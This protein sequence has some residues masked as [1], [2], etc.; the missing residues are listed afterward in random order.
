MARSRSPGGGGGGGG[1][2][3]YGDGLNGDG[4]S[5]KRFLKALSI[6]DK[7][8]PIGFYLKIRPRVGRLF[9]V[10]VSSDIGIYSLK[11]VI[12]SRTSD[13]LNHLGIPVECQRLRFAG[14]LL[15][16]RRT[17]SDYNIPCGA[18]VYCG[19]AENCIEQD[20]V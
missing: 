1:G 17:L 7:G 15:E 14:Q 4:G 8:K 12:S 5:A 6:N 16:N 11:Q 9:I 19:W 18:V 13:D 2:G 3:G 20:D 10:L